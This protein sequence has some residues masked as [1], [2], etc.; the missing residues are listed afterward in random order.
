MSH[1]P[2]E[3]EILS[4]ERGV[5]ERDGRGRLFDG[6]DVA[7]SDLFYGSVSESCRCIHPSD[8]IVLRASAWISASA[9][10]PKGCRM[11]SLLL[12]CEYVRV[13]THVFRRREEIHRS[14]QFKLNSS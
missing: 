3:E 7:V 6:G 14:G 2:E 9:D 1:L 4:S 13:M 8:W 12:T 11:L 5:A 10:I